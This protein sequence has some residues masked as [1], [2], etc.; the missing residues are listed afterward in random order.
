M[1]RFILCFFLCICTVQAAPKKVKAT[2]PLTV[3]ER[4]K[5]LTEIQDFLKKP[6][7]SLQDNDLFIY[8]IEES[9]IPEIKPIEEEVP[10]PVVYSKDDF[11][12]TVL[13][14]VGGAIKPE[15]SL[16]TNGQY[17]LCLD[18]RRVLKVGDKLYAKFRGNEYIITLKS[19]TRNTFTLEINNK[20]QTFHYY[21]KKR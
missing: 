10:K 4:K 19:T 15:G 12:Q 1:Y 9:P 18:G 21:I 16:A 13:K 20:E 6:I 5:I 11:D 3:A 17:A 14:A 8:K 2:P 7:Y